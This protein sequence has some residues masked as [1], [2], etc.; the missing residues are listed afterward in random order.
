[1]TSPCNPM[2]AKNY[3]T[4]LNAQGF[5]PTYLPRYTFAC[6]TYPV[7]HCDSISLARSVAALLLHF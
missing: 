4:A 5:I 1:M 2:T 3:V 6:D 7:L